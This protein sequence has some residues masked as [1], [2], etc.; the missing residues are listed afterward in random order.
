M[1]E[2]R[3]PRRAKSGRVWLAAAAR[4][5]RVTMV[6]RFLIAAALVI[7]PAAARR[8]APR[9]GRKGEQ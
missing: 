4:G 3:E 9:R 7:T 1:I 8:H 2:F 6:G 5:K